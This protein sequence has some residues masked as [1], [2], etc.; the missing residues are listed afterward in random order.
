MILV[1]WHLINVPKDTPVYEVA[2][3]TSQACNSLTLNLVKG[4]IDMLSGNLLGCEVNGTA[5]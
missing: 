3:K 4:H 2:D 5:E 1:Q